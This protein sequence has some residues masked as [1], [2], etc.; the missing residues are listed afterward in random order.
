MLPAGFELGVATSA[1]QIEGAFDVDGRGPGIWDAFARRPGAIVDGS[2]ASRACDHYRRVEEDVALLRRLGVDSYRF[3]VA[4]PRVQPDG[5]GAVDP[6]GLDHY[7]RLV[8]LLLEAGIAPTVTLFHHD[9]P[10]ALEDDGGWLNP[11]T[12]EHY[13]AYAAIVGERLVDR[14]R[15]WIPV[16]DPAVASVRGYGDGT[17][18]PGWKLSFDGLWASHHLLMAHGRGAIAL[19]GAG[20][21]SVGCANS[22]APMWPASEDVADVGATKLFDALWNG[23][24]LEPML[25]GRY[26]VDLQPLMEPIVSHG[27]LATIRQ[28]LDFYGVNY[29]N[30]MRVAAAP[31]DDEAPFRLLPLVGYPE[32]DL[33]RP[34]VPD[35]LREWLI[36]FRSR[37]RNALPPIMVTES[38]CA[39]AGDPDEHGK[40]DDRHRI[41][42]H[43]DHLQ[44]VAEAIRRGVDVRGYT[45]WSLLD[46]WE[47]V[48]G[49]TQRFGLV[50]VDFETFERTP[51]ASF[52]WY[53][54]LIAAQP[55]HSG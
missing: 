22:H 9:L 16:H 41:A 27:D 31:E 48:E 49:Y 44:A 47:W 21:T 24:F 43:R 30:P 34:I 37:F 3:S 32:T 38:G 50:H 2:D 39:F 8:D 29:Y 18:A 36:V 19:R 51:K 20:A 45:A 54:A 46:C 23:L 10:A 11:A 14:V 7:D 1:Y 26:P 6:R 53:A 13:A 17:H 52:D 12:V 5:R 55:Q 25:L 42:Y 4:W 28:P 15:H 33:G 40:V 35:A